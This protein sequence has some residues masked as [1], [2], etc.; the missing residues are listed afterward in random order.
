MGD[1]KGNKGRNREKRIK[2][3]DGRM[4]V[5]STQ[6]GGALGCGNELNSDNDFG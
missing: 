1:G 5:R 4:S 2:G 3:G 6:R